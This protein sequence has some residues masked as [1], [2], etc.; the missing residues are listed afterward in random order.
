MI[1]SLIEMLQLTNSDHM[2]T[3]TISFES[4]DKILLVTSYTEIMTSSPLFQKAIILERPGIAIWLTSSKLQPCLLRQS[5]K[6]QEKLKELETVYENAIYICISS[7]STICWF[8]VK[9]LLAE[10]KGCVTWF[11]YFLELLYGGGHLFAPHPWVAP[12]KPILHR[13]KQ[14]SKFHQLNCHFLSKIN[15]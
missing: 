7:Y 6:T 5:L 15:F 12:K 10:A 14:I 8:P 13:V 4:R 1:T 11:M 3:S 9:M 2:T